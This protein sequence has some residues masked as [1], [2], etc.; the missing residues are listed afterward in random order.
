[1]NRTIALVLV[2]LLA[3]GCATTGGVTSFT[4]AGDTANLH[5]KERRLWHEASGVDSTIER[6]G[7]IYE[8]R[9]ATA[10]LQGVMDRLYPEFKGKIQVHLYD[11]TQL[12]AF[13]LPNGSIYFNIGLLA[14]MENE[15]QLAA[16]LAHEAAH[17][18]EKHSFRQRVSAKNLSAFAVSGIPFA[19]LAAVSSI[20]GFSRDLEREADMK[21]YER[22]T[23]AGYDPHEAHK[24]FEHLAS[25]VKAL[26]IEEPYFFSSHP[27]LVERIETFKELSAR[28]KKGG[29]VGAEDY[30]RVMQAIRLDALRKDVGQD[31]YKSVI[32]V[33]E[34]PGLR[35]YYPASGYY[36]LGEAYSRRDEKGDT[37]RAL[38]A[39]QKAE[40]LSPRFAPT[41]KSLGMHYMKTGNKG[42]ARRYFGKYLSLAS[43]DARDRAYVQQY[44]SSL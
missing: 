42:Q 20:S 39:W 8:D 37:A 12:N 31:R 21:G 27:Q 5:E 10:Y 24:V 18:I 25:E 23:K 41:Y 30:N 40:K 34:D 28:R 43:K 15:A 3:S 4:N 2:S 17:F 6:S 13:A 11:S 9:R 19:S 1:M 29:R 38:Q 32:L 44:M 26:G 36:Y 35:R 7:Q 33:M 16:V 14:R 22:L